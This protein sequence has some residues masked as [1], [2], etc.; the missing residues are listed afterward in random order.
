MMPI[1]HDPPRTEDAP[2]SVIP[3]DQ[4]V[5]GSSPDP[6]QPSPSAAP[7]WSRRTHV[8]ALVILAVA[9]I[10]GIREF[11][12]GDAKALSAMWSRTVS[13][14][15]WVFLFAV[16]DVAIEASAWM[17]VFERFGLRARDP[18][19]IAVAVSGKAGLLLPAQLGRLLRPELMVRLG[20]SSL[21]DSL[22]AE[23]AVFLLDSASV[24]ALLAA[25]V[26]WWVN[27]LLAPVAGAAV[28]VT[29]LFLAHRV[30]PLLSGT[31][32]Q[33]P[34]RFWWSPKTFMI[35]VLQSG[36]W[37]AHGLAFW[38]LAS[39]L[40]GNVGVLDAL[41]L[42]PGSAVLGVGS[43]LP[44]GLG[45]TELLLGASLGIR[46]VPE[47]QLGLGVALFRVFT[48]WM[49]LPIGWLAVAFVSIVVKRGERQ[50]E[51]ETPAG[52]ER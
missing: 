11:V 51:L 29:C 36:G 25:L 7:L 33:M 2:A 6:T 45:A 12:A 41:L 31:A 37:V 20:R 32:L 15:P 49:W 26:S 19:G 1:R 14:L 22:K 24:V 48:F 9:S 40:D 52:E 23:A 16:L 38:M 46:S 34:R 8:F 3:I 35:V 4:P 18:V 27:P 43:G 28:I 42:A 17:L 21:G 30:A 44:G 5:E 47:A 10:W 39:A 13:V 50:D